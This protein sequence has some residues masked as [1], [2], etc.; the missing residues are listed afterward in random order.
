MVWSAVISLLCTARPH[1]FSEQQ[2]G[3]GS[4][5]LALNG[6]M[7]EQTAL[8]VAI[9]NHHQEA[10]EALIEPSAASGA[11]VIKDNF[12]NWTALVYACREGWVD[13][14]EKIFEAASKHNVEDHALDI[15]GALHIAK[16]QSCIDLLS[17]RLDGAI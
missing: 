12:R 9:I 2:L 7:W 13:T 16:N 5:P 15:S 14:V 6:G 4:R 3:K 17:R 10:T 11:L 8:I 1:P